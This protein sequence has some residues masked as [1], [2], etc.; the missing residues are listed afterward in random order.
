MVDWH[1]FKKV[2]TVVASSSVNSNVN[3]IPSG[4]LPNSA[5]S[6]TANIAPVSAK[7]VTEPVTNQASLGANNPVTTP[8]QFSGSAELHEAGSGSGPD[9]SGLASAFA[10]EPTQS[11]DSRSSKPQAAGHAGKVEQGK[12][13]T[14]DRPATDTEKS[15]KKSSGK[16]V[17]EQRDDRKKDQEIIDHVCG[18][19]CGCGSAKVKDS[20]PLKALHERDNEVRQHEQ[21][22]LEA[23]GE[24]AASGPQFEMTKASDGR[25]YVTGGH[26]NVNTDKVSG[27]PVKTLEK[28]KKLEKAAL[29]P[30]EPS[31]ADRRIASESRAKAAEAFN[32]ITDKRLKG[33]LG[34]DGKKLDGEISLH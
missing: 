5:N 33:E 20:D 1:K 16:S 11:R 22:H 8:D 2:D 30:A 13:A 10:D 3:L 18:K 9:L 34:Q 32:E 19:G 12:D 24:H 7:G 17:T 21:E 26:V 23:A 4:S 15:V 28:M 31:D 27:D 29:R 6:A 14:L 25:S